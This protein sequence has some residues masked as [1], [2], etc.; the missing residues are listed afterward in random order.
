MSVIATAASSM[1][2]STCWP[3]PVRS[4]WRSAASTPIDANNAALMSPERADGVGPGRLVGPAH[5]LVDP[6]HRLDD[7]RVCGPVPVRRVGRPEAGHRD[8]DGRGMR[9]GDGRVAEAQ[10]VHRAGLEVL[11]D[12]VEPGHEPE[13]E[14]RGPRRTSSRWP[15]S[16]CP[17]CC[18]G[19]WRRPSAPRGRFIEGC[20]PRPGLAAQRLDLDDVGAEAGQQ[21][22]GVRQRLHLLGGEHPHAVERPAHP[23]HPSPKSRR[24]VN[25]CVDDSSRVRRWVGSL[26]PSR[27]RR[28]RR[29]TPSRPG[30]RRG[31]G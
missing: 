31:C 10:A 28:S 16:A 8:V 23:A 29:T 4:R 25:G 6:R 11:G 24:V 7:R 5:V 22:R 17:G 9:R 2:T 26:T 27:W 30:S 14:R 1:A 15:R 20:D 21:L 12:H 3:S 19:T 13:E 18:A